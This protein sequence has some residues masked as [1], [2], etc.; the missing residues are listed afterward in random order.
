MQSVISLPF[1][2]IILNCGTSY[3]SVAGAFYI[4]ILK[5]LTFCA[6][7]KTSGN[8]KNAAFASS[9][10]EKRGGGEGAREESILKFSDQRALFFFFF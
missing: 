10:E 8:C 2:I 5:Q 6:H 7:R 9:I 3:R 4:I 1:C